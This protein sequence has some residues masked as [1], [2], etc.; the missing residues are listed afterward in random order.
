MNR[1]HTGSD[2]ASCLVRCLGRVMSSDVCANLESSILIVT[3]TP[4]GSRLITYTG[5]YLFNPARRTFLFL[6]HRV[7]DVL[8]QDEF[9]PVV[10]KPVI[11]VMEDKTDT[12]VCDLFPILQFPNSLISKY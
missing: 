8:Q 9:V 10:F 1:G 3:N 5:K 6:V 12:H 4:Q 2:D 11:M 7:F